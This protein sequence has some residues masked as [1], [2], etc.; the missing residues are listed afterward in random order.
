MLNGGAANGQASPEPAP[1]QAARQLQRRAQTI[2]DR[3]TPHVLYRWLA[4][5][6]VCVVY[7]IRVFNLEGFYIVSYALGIYNLNLLLGFLTPQVDPELEGPT[8]PSKSDE[9]FRPFVRKLP[10]FKAWYASIRSLL[11][12]FAATFFAAFDIPV[13]WPILVLYWFVLFFVTM[14][15]QILHMVKYRYL[16]FSWGKKT[17]GSGKAPR[18]E[19][20]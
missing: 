5:A 12:G 1:I 2:L 6:F 14:K 10:E 16:P 8:L 4:W 11:L 15:K 17:Y 3:T 20:K 19:T 13:F 7:A 18:K 9:E